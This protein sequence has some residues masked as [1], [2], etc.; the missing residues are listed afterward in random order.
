MHMHALAFLNLTLYEV[1]DD[2]HRDVIYTQALDEVC[3]GIGLYC[4]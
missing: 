3:G 2:E 1:S 4:H